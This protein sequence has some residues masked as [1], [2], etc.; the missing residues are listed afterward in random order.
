MTDEPGST[1]RS[2]RLLDRLADALSARGYV[3]ALRQVYRESTRTATPVARHGPDG[4]PSAL[5]LLGDVSDVEVHAALEATQAL[6][7]PAQAR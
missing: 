6:G 5:D 2:P 4:V 7:Q 1:P 3:A